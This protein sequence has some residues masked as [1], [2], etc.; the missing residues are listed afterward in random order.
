MGIEAWRCANLDIEFWTVASSAGGGSG[1]DNGAAMETVGTAA[2]ASPGAAG[3]VA[4]AN[5]WVLLED[6]D[7]GLPTVECALLPGAW[8]VVAPLTSCGLH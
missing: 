5:S 2:D 3:G 8:L 7:F 4:E 6:G 1:D